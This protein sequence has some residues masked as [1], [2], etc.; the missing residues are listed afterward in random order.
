MLFLNEFFQSRINFLLIVFLF[1]ELYSRLI[2]IPPSKRP[3]NNYNRLLIKK[4][5][6]IFYKFSLWCENF[7]GAKYILVCSLHDFFYDFYKRLFFSFWQEPYMKLLFFFWI[8]FYVILW[9]LTLIFWIV[10]LIYWFMKF[11]WH[12]FYYR[13]QIPEEVLKLNYSRQDAPKWFI[14][15]DLNAINGWIPTCIHWASYRYHK[16]IDLDGTTTSITKLHKVHSLGAHL[17]TFLWI[18]VISV[19]YFRAYSF[20]YTVVSTYRKDNPKNYMILLVVFLNLIKA[21]IFF[22]IF[23]IPLFIFYFALEA[24]GHAMT[25]NFILKEINGTNKYKHF[26]LVEGQGSFYHWYIYR[27]MF[28]EMLRKNYIEDSARSFLVVRGI[29]KPF[30][31]IRI[32]NSLLFLFSL[33]IMVVFIYT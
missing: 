27:Q 20:F 25:T 3:K 13:D 19:P 12:K 33:L 28:L 9:P 31:C 26:T 15:P 2:F 10:W 11:W 32:P 8:I 18:F 22:Y 30:M 5:D 29:E 1:L 23:G 17:M 7:T 21:I 4:L 16:A 6:R 24:T 14:H